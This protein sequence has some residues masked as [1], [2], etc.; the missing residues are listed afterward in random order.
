M[1][2][3]L[4][5]NAS[6]G[7]AYYMAGKKIVK[8]APVFDSWKATTTLYTELYKGADKTGPIAG[9]GILS[10]GMA[11]LMAM[12][13]TMHATNASSPEE[14]AKAAA[15]FGKFFLGELWETYAIRSGS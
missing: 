8:Q 13:P 15:E 4:G 9:A 2:Y 11:D 3:E 7:D 10:L 5:F 12:I 6:N 1:V 14:E